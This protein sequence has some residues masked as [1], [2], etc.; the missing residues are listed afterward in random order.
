[1]TDKSLFESVCFHIL[2]NYIEGEDKVSLNLFSMLTIMIAKKK[3]T[4]QNVTRVTESV[5][6]GWS[7]RRA[8]HQR[9]SDA[10]HSRFTSR[11]HSD[12]QG[13]RLQ[14]C[15]YSCK[16]ALIHICSSNCTIYSMSQTCSDG[17]TQSVQASPH[18]TVH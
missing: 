6:S 4:G 18:V 2:E 5:S 13:R 10:H 9:A 14:S 12:Y 16:V 17:D 3:I 8:F 15:S 7:D 1:M 11:E